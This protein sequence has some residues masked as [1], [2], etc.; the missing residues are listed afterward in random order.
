MTDFSGKAVLVTGGG[1][2][3]G[4]G[5]TS[6]FAKRG[7]SVVICQPTQDEADRLAAHLSHNIGNVTGVGANLARSDACREVVERCIALHGRIDVLVNNAAV[8]GPP[9]T[10]DILEFDD[11]RVDHLVDVNLK[12]PFR[13]ARNAAHYMRDGGGGVIINIASV[14]AY[15]AQHRATV[16]VTTKAGITGLTRGMA[17]ELAPY[18]IRVVAV[19]PGDIDLE[20]AAPPGGENPYDSQTREWWTRRSPLGRRG[21]PDDIAHAVVYLASEEASYI[22]GTTVVVDGGWLSY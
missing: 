17:F 13:C 10:G 20:R 9:A 4:A 15:A 16:Y 5:I 14:G 2:G 12:A 6:L 7:A 19:A 11:D 8:T 3:I 22:T 1:T 21:S 18:G